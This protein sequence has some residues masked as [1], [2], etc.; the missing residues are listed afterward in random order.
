MHLHSSEAF[1]VWLKHNTILRFKI[2]IHKPSSSR[3][4]KGNRHG[5]GDLAARQQG[6]LGTLETRGLIHYLKDEAAIWFQTTVSIQRYNLT[7]SRSALSA[8]AKGLDFC[9]ILQFLKPEKIKLK[10]SVR[11]YVKDIC[12]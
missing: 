10:S 1:F 7:A 9:E 3:A 8:E 12:A 4:W 11:F 5:Q 2:R 6:V